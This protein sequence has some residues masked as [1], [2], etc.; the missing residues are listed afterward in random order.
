MCRPFD[1][2]ADG[3]VL[4]EGGS[5]AVLRPLRDA[6]A[7]GDRIYAVLNGIGTGND[8][9]GSGPMT[10]R[11]EGQEAAMRA[12]YRDAGVTPGRHRLP[13]GTRHRHDG[14]RPG[15]DRGGTA[16]A[17][18][19]RRRAA[20]LPVVRKGD[21]RAHPAGGG[22]AGVLRTALALHHRTVPPQSAFTAHPDLPLAAAGL[23]IT[24]E[25]REW[26]EVPDDCSARRRQ[27][28]RFRR[29]QRARRAQRGVR[30]AGA[31]RR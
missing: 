24:T 21:H 10:P 3:F 1:A 6:V 31:R 25:A 15:R 4:G 14:R 12:A 20:L 23:E 29:H 30:S 22:A 11:A 8:G 17:R 27:L 16:A 18:D 13:R 26:P 9:K 19:G 5:L 28:V 2:R 7:V